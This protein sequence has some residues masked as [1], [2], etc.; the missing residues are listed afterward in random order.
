[1]TAT[2]LVTMCVLF[3]LAVPVAISIGL[4]AIAGLGVY[5]SLPLVLVAQQAFASLDK[6]PLA[7]VPF[8]ILA[9]NLMGEGGISSRLVD[10]AKS[11]VGGVQGGLACTCAIAHAQM[12]NGWPLFAKAAR[13][14]DYVALRE[15]PPAPLVLGTDPLQNVLVL[16][17]ARHATGADD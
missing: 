2:M 1:M 14:R 4:A 11:I 10:F 5:T 7:A 8:F 9:G 13:T 12:R 3:L 17:I 15:L 6:F 16:G